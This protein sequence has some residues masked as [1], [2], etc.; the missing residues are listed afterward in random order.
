MPAPSSAS[1][2]TASSKRPGQLAPPGRGQSTSSTVFVGSDSGSAL[3]EIDSTRSDLP[4]NAVPVL[5]AA[6]KVR[7]EGVRLPAAAA[8][9]HLLRRPD[10]VQDR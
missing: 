6:L 9:G 8:L 5:L 3:S 1:A 10:A 7:E 2:A 4:S